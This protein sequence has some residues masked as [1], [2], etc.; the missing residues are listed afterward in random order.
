[1][2][3][4]LPFSWGA[5]NLYSSIEMSIIQAKKA[6][7]PQRGSVRLYIDMMIIL[8]GGFE[9]D[10]L[11]KNSLISNVRGDFSPIEKTMGLYSFLNRY[12]NE[13]YGKGGVFF[14]ESL[15]KFKVF[16]TNDIYVTCG[17]NFYNIH[18]LLKYI[19]PQRYEFVGSNAIDHLHAFSEEYAERNN[20]ARTKQRLYLIIVMFLFGCSFE[21]D[22]LYK[23]LNVNDLNNYLI[24]EDSV[25]HDLIAS[26]Y[27]CLQINCN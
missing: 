20:I 25:S 22:L 2:F 14:I 13:V 10:L 3:P 8:G 23:R 19:Y 1:M 9:K 17:N 6:G 21:H 11:F 27:S 26:S 15:N 7:Y 24:K 4:L 18:D 16:N 12:V 5:D